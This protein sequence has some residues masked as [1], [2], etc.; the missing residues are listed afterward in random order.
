[1]NPFIGSQGHPPESEGSGGWRVSFSMKVN[2]PE[3]KGGARLMRLRKTPRRFTNAEPDGGLIL[4]LA[5]DSCRRLLRVLALN[6][7]PAEL[8]PDPG[9]RLLDG[10]GLERLQAARDFIFTASP[11]EDAR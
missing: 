1:M 6:L 10:P 5:R 4:A 2:S 11:S 9:K 3:T 7:R 8:L